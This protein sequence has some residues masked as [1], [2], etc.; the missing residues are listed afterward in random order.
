MK[1]L[2]LLSYLVPLIIGA[3]IAWAVIPKDNEN[4]KLLEQEKKRTFIQK[5]SIDRLQILL[6][7]RDTL[8]TRTHAQDRDS[9]LMARKQ[10]NYWR[11]ENKK[12]RSAPVPLYNEHQLDS[13]VDALIQARHN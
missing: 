4:K 2:Q 3:L 1:P 7:R 6:A 5:D 11:N 10:S 13:A 8:W 12:I 9:L